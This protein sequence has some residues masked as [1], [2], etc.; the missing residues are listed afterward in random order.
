MEIVT[1]VLLTAL[2]LAAPELRRLIFCATSAQKEGTV[3]VLSTHQK[4]CASE[5]VRGVA[6]LAV[7][8]IHTARLLINAQHASIPGA[9]LFLE[10]LSRF[11]IGAFLITSGA[12]LAPFDLRQRGVLTRFFAPKFK[13]VLLP[14]LLCTIG[15]GLVHGL[16]LERI[17]YDVLHGSAAVP[18]YFVPVL[19][20]CYLL[21]PLLNI[22]RANAYLLTIAFAISLTC[23]LVPSLWAPGGF[24]LAGCYLFFFAYGVAAGEKL[25]M[26]PQATEKRALLLIPVAYA[27]CCLV[28]VDRYSNARYIYAP[29][30]TLLLF[31]SLRDSLEPKDNPA[32][33][34]PVIRKISSGLGKRSL[35]IFLLHYPLAK[36][37]MDAGVDSFHTLLFLTTA[38]SFAGATIASIA[39]ERLF[40]GDLRSTTASAAAKADGPQEVGQ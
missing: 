26:W 15:L 31:W 3:P 22:Y 39:H 18:Y 8:I 23:A 7:I 17:G 21:Y 32:S 13:R 20:Q 5:A 37:L 38:A 2:C 6:I 40:G 1:L 34:S 33:L 16:S 27:L 19:F 4:Y 30:I 11:A 28:F 25:W 10:N 14:Y 12:L 36:I 9:L 35:W 24:P 29:A